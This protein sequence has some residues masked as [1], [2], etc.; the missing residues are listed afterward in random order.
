[1]GDEYPSAEIL[2]LDLSPIQPL[3]VPSNV[4]FMVDDVEEPW[5]KGENFYDLVHG[6]HITP[7]IKDFPT[8]LKRSFKYVLPALWVNRDNI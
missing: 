7:A 5:L 3:W 2:G 8:L 1:V 6:R 4:R